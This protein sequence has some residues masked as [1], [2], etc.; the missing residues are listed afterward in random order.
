MRHEKER[1]LVK[2]I[3]RKDDVKKE[4]KKERIQ[5]KDID[6]LEFLEKQLSEKFE[7]K[8]TD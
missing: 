3:Q 2:Q 7:K 1:N 8:L 5:S 4:R 6:N